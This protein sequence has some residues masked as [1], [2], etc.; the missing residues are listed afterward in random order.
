M[1]CK[2]F[3]KLMAKR[4]R[5]WPISEGG[6]HT[7]WVVVDYLRPASPD[8]QVMLW[9]WT[10][11]KREEGEEISSGGVFLKNRRTALTRVEKKGFHCNTLCCTWWPKVMNTFTPIGS[12]HSVLRP[13]CP[14][15]LC[16]I[17]FSISR[18]DLRCVL[19]LMAT[20]E[21][22]KTEVTFRPH[23][24]RDMHISCSCIFK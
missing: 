9:K 23:C 15:S 2:P 17:S 13:P 5:I 10:V 16:T 24:T 4:G 21:W 3:P 22:P 8:T 20:S 11:I 18:F 12:H 14:T 19:D 6:K 1:M 7:T